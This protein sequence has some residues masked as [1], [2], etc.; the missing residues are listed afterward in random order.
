MQ[1]MVNKKLDDLQAMTLAQRLRKLGSEERGI[2]GKLQKNLG[3]TIGLLPKDLPPKFEKA[4]SVFA[5]SQTRAEE[6]SKTLQG[7]ISRFFER[8]KE[9]NYGQ[10]SQEMAAAKTPEELDKVRGLISENISMEAMRHLG[11]WSRQF[12]A[13]ADILEPKPSS[14]GGAGGGGGGQGNDLAN[15]LM[16][17]L[18]ALLRLRDG[19]LNV[20]DRTQL[21]EAQKLDP[22]I[23]QDGAGAVY[24]AQRQLQKKLLQMQMDNPFPPLEDPFSEIY[25]A[26]HTVGA[27]LGLPQTDAVT[28]KAETKSVE[29]ISDVINLINEQIQRG[30]SSQSSTAEEMAFLLQMMSP[31]SR[32]TS[33][34][35]M[36]RNPGRSTMGGTTQRPAGPL[37]G[38]AQGKGPDS[39]NVN[40][41]SGMTENVPTE[42]REA[43]ENYFEA[44]D[45]EP[46]R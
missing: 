5:A 34:M 7:E 27:L 31:E 26:M 8:T 4:N 10:V 28:V 18:L 38:A 24:S 21:L 15:V 6:E 12:N 37:E 29:V 35:T 13:W 17:Q 43:L 41:A 9:K 16:E 44:L 42:F 40:K 3:Q 33:G 30:G 23:Y 22:A 20:R 45:K 14:A 39:R 11:Q 19:E 25:D 46:N 36:S 32:E 1:Q 2:E